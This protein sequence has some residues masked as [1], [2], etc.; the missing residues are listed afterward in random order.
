[1]TS[2]LLIYPFFRGPVDRSRFR[3]PPLGVAY[4]AASLRQAGHDVAL[5]DCTFLRRD[6]ALS[7]ALSTDAEIVGISCMVTMLDD[8][9]WFARRLRDRCSLL[10]AGGPLPTCNPEAFADDFDVVVRGEGEAALREI[11]A[12]SE[13]GDDVGDVAGAVRGAAAGR[14]PRTPGQPAPRPFIRNLDALPF[15]ARDLLPN[16]AYIAFGRRRYGHAVT[17]VMTTRGCPYRCEFC[18]NVVFGNSYRERSPG[19]VVDEIEEALRLGYDHIS[20]ADD[21]FTLNRDRVR[22]LCDE[23][24]RRR[25]RFT[26]ECL[27]RVDRLDAATAT[28]MRRAGCR[29]VYLGI[30]S[31][32]ERTLRLMRKESTTEQAR[33]AVAAARSAG[34]EVGAFF[35]VGY[36]G[37]D[38]DGVLA[39]L[40]LAT[41]LPLA[42][43]GFTLPYPLPGTDLRRRVGEQATREWRPRDS[44]VLNQVLTY[45][46]DFSAAKLRFAVLKGRTQVIMR[47][48]L[49]RFAPLP[50]RGFARV[51]DELFRRLP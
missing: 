19:N 50:L 21:V 45:D 12:A 51:T 8:C 27:A 6:E 4:L 18:S 42:Y 24:E 43:A 30:E 41:S 28:R 15:P 1:M 22:A 36:P 47:Q 25:L 29:R 39:T 48:R 38:D 34:L 35:I 11:V 13:T 5:L 49:G 33:Q 46:G 31:G 37:E 23:I 9:L 3:F 17:T 32:D 2:V 44:P 14:G 10:V 26:W 16:S 7:A 40:R 20:F